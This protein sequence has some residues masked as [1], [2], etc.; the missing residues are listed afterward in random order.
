MV[1]F[2]HKKCNRGGKR[3]DWWV[4]DVSGVDGG[5]MR[6]EM[7]VVGRDRSLLRWGYVVTHRNTG[8]V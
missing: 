6:G 5:E 3:V 1:V 2:F 4:D 8:L 7:K